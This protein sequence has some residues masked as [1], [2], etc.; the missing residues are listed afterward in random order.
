LAGIDPAGFACESSDRLGAG[1]RVESVAFADD[2]L[3][4]FLAGFGLSTL[5]WPERVRDKKR[6]PVATSRR[7]K[8]D[9]TATDSLFFDQFG[10]IGEP[11][12]FVPLLI[13]ILLLAFVQRRV[14]R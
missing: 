10:P 1:E 11:V 8:N 9:I 6:I 12:V 7:H 13:S 2:D 3:D 4:S 5:C 14:D